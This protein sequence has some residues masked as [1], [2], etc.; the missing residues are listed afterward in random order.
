MGVGKSH[1]GTTRDILEQ[2]NGSVWSV[3]T[4]VGGG[5]QPEQISCPAAG[6]C[7]ALGLLGGAPAAAS[8]SG[9]HWK[10]MPAPAPPR[11]PGGS[12]QPPAR[13]GFDARPGPALLGRAS[14]ALCLCA[15]PG[16][17]L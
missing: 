11:V 13:T 9:G 8:Y 16:C 12:L 15:L 6:R 4:T 3:A 5:L 10:A 17:H 2:W 7:L 1:T 14:A